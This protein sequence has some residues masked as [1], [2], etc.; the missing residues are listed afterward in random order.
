MRITLAGGQVKSRV[1]RSLR[2]YRFSE[3]LGGV[4]ER[5]AALSTSVM[6]LGER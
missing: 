6:D 2:C 3:T 1:A 4:G 5:H